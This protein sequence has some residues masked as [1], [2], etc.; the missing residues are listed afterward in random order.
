M[1]TCLLS[2][3]WPRWQAR[4]PSPLFPLAAAWHAGPQSGMPAFRE[5]GWAGSVAQQRFVLGLV[6]GVRGEVSLAVLLLILDKQ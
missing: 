1:H 5:K 6:G 2:S 4:P 3:S